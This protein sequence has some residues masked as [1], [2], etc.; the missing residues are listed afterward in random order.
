MRSKTASAPRHPVSCIV[1][2]RTG[3]TLPYCSSWARTDTVRDVLH[4]TEYIHLT[5]D[6]ILGN[7]DTKAN[8][9]S[10]PKNRT[11]A[12]RG[13]WQSAS[14]RNFHQASATQNP[15]YWGGLGKVKEGGGVI[16]SSWSEMDKNTDYRY[17]GVLRSKGR[18]RKYARTPT[19]RTL[20]AMMARM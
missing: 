19:T 8:V 20:G 15:G 9:S 11:M 6:F 18:N 1:V 10:E 3:R 7:H 14:H 16:D 12:R 17:N 5:L 13:N 2:Y 4:H